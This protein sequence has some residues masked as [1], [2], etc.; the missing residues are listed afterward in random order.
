[1][2]VEQKNKTIE[3]TDLKN[4]PKSS[5]NRTSNPS[6]HFYGNFIVVAT[7]SKRAPQ[8]GHNFN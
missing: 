1:M 7:L 4:Q 6:Q 5:I 3:F 8:P 2:Y